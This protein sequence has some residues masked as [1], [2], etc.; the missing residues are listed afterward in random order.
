M[1]MCEDTLTIL[2]NISNN[3]VTFMS[4]L[5]KLLL[6]KNDAQQL[7]T[8]QILSCV[9]H[10]DHGGDYIES[11]LSSDV[12]GKDSCELQCSPYLYRSAVALSSLISF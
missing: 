9:L 8:T 3:G 2:M 12:V 4:T 5:K 6:S 7:S 11:V 1:V 10:T